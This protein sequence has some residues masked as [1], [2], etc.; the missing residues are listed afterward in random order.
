MAYILK[1]TTSNVFIKGKKYTCISKSHFRDKIIMFV[2]LFSFCRHDKL[3]I[4]F[5]S[6]ISALIKK[7]LG[8]NQC[9]D[10][11]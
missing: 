2:L 11:H 6:L 3:K 1:A 10:T 7:I 9:A 5:Q 4:S 8:W